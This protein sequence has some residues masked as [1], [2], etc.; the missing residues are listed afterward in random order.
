MAKVNGVEVFVGI[1]TVVN[2]YGE[3][4][5]Q[6]LTPTKGYSHVT[7]TLTGISKS[8]AKYGHSPVKY[9]YTDNAKAERTFLERVIPS[10]RDDVE[11]INI[12]AYAQ[13]PLFEIPPTV[14]VIELSDFYMMGV[15]SDSICEA[16][17]DGPTVIGFD[18]EWNVDLSTGIHGKTALIQIAWDQSIYL[19]HVS[20]LS[21]NEAMS[22]N[23][24]ISVVG[25]QNQTVAS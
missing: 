8:L 12:A 14:Q 20:F 25:L 16:A 11:P 22:Y 7:Q 5:G 24:L 15:L 18:S 13:L 23:S 4:R 6:A 2:E 10:L 1:Y 21:R 9:F 17:K 3:I 19:C